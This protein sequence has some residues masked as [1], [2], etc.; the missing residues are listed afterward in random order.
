MGV[1]AARGATAGIPIVMA[2][3]TRD[4]VAAGYIASLARPGGNVTGFTG[5]GEE[6][7]AKQL[8]LLRDLVPGLTNV[9]IIYNSLSPGV[10][11]ALLD[12]IGKAGA[13]LGLAV[14]DAGVRYATDL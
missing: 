1:R 3:T 5:Q 14:R 13:A 9:A 10:S 4:P 11:R 12:E 6:L 7:N 8:E 2:M